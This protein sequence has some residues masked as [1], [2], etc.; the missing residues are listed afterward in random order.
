MSEIAK[1]L[2]RYV[3]G[4]VLVKILISSTEVRNGR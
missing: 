2:F 1:S 4:S 3:P